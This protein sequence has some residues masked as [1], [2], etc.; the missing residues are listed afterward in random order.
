M[1][2]LA[3]NERVMKGIRPFFLQTMAGADA[4]P[5]IFVREGA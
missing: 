5:C 2:H 3:G 1:K 4:A